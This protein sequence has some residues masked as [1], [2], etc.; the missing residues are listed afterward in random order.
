VAAIDIYPFYIA[1]IAVATK[2]RN[3]PAI[4]NEHA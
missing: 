4:V 1:L 3:T 2:H